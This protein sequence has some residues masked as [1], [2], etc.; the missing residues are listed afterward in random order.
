MNLL[1]EHGPQDLKSAWMYFKHWAKGRPVGPETCPTDPDR[2]PTGW[3]KLV[4]DFDKPPVGSRSDFHNN[5]PAQLR[6][7]E[8][9]SERPMQAGFLQNVNRAH[10]G[11]VL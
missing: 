3:T 2:E 9:R 4:H 10:C 1:A 5:M 7:T 8:S 6:D 11:M